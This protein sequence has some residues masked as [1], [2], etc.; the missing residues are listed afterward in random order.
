V[1]RQ[2]DDLLNFYFLLWYIAVNQIPTIRC[3]CG[4]FQGS[5]NKIQSATRAICYC[6]D[7]QIY[8]HYLAQAPRILNPWGGTE[9]FAVRPRQIVINQG[10]ENLACLSLTE[11]GAWRFYTSCCQTP[12]ANMTRNHKTL[13]IALIH[14]CVQHNDD[15]CGRVVQVKRSSAIGVPP[16]NKITDF[17]ITALHYACSVTFAWLARGYR[18]NP[19][20]SP[21][22]GVPVVRPIILADGELNRLRLLVKE[23]KNT[24]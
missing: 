20:I 1:W 6:D 7:C 13:H 9:V 5:I 3:K 16:T 17:V 18:F 24:V 14:C 2:G 19:F 23:H 22:A 12:I 21:A 8:A 15:A 4:K 10:L 11:S